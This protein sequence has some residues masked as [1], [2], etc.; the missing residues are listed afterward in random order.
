M[1][2]LEFGV[3]FLVGSKFV[4]LVVMFVSFRLMMV[5]IV[6]IVVGGNSM[7]SQLVF[8]FFMIKEIRQNSM[9]YIIK[10]FSVILY[11]NG[12]SNNIGEI[13]VKLELR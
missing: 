13:K 3:C 5:M 12:N 2:V 9:L 1:M 8:V 6:F 4:I 10:L 11:F 7:F